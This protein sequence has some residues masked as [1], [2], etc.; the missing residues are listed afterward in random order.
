MCIVQLYNTIVPEG[1]NGV[2]DAQSCNP[3]SCTYVSIISSFIE[4]VFF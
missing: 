3:V 2:R 1:M 4:A